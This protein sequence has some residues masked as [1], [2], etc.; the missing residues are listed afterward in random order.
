MGLMSSPMGL[1]VG[2]LQHETR[3]KTLYASSS[4]PSPP[5]GGRSGAR[6]LW[7]TCA[8]AAAAACIYNCICCPVLEVKLIVLRDVRVCCAT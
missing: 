5:P 7:A 2:R 1:M 6:R 3:H 4:S 8:A